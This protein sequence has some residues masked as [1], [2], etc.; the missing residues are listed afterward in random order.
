MAQI[1]KN[2]KYST[3]ISIYI[4]NL[5]FLNNFIISSLRLEMNDFWLKKTLTHFLLFR[6]HTPEKKSPR[7]TG[8]RRLFKAENRADCT[9]IAL[10]DILC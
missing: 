7:T 6:Q 9:A 2:S 3:L 10:F 1:H 8:M 4:C 5:R